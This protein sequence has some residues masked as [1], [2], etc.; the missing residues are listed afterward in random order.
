[1]EGSELTLP[2]LRKFGESLFVTS[3]FLKNN[4]ATHFLSE[5][6]KNHSYDINLQRQVSLDIKVVS[7]KINNVMYAYEGRIHLHTYLYIIEAIRP[8]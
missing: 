8:K 7:E 1:M 6:V 5:C 2:A 4:N 3:H